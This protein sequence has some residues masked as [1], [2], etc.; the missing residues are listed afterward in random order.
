MVEVEGDGDGGGAGGG[1]GGLGEEGG[2]V[3]LGPGEEEDHC[4]G[5]F[6]GGG[7]DGGE[8][9]F[10][11]VLMVSTEEMS[12]RMEKLGRFG[13]IGVVGEERRGLMGEGFWGED[14][15]TGCAR[16]A[17][18]DGCGDTHNA[19]ARNA[20]FALSSLLQHDIGFVLGQVELGILGCWFC[21]AGSRGVET[22]CNGRALVMSMSL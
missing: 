11:V 9:A 13:G 3:G 20:V 12:M 19:D 21:H 1:G 10:E 8:D 15:A 17:S 5:A 18:R 7:A 14:A 22:R 16:L 2:G 4:W 6:G